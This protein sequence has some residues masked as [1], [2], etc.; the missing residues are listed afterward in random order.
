MRDLLRLARELFAGSRLKLCATLAL[1]A[2]LTSITGVGL[3][4]ILPLLGL[5]GLAP[6]S[7]DNPVWHRLGELLGRFGISLTLVTGL[8]LFAAVVC[9][10]ALLAWRRETWQVEVEQDFQTTLR[11][12]LYESLS[13]TELQYLQRL[14]TSEFVQAT[15]GEI[16]RVQDAV[17]VLFQLV[18]TVLRLLVYFAVALYL[19]PQMTL[20]VFASG[21]LVV[22]AMR[23]M[24]K[25][26]HLLSRQQV[27]VRGSMINNL[28]EHIQGL[29]TARSLGLTQRFIDDYRARSGQAARVAVELTR[30]SSRSALVFEVVAAVLLA[31]LVYVG[32]ARLEVEPARFIV[33]VLVFIRTFPT[34][35]MFQ[36]QLQRLV[37]LVPSFLHYAE[38]LDDLE[39][40]EEK[41]TAG[42]EGPAL[43]LQQ[44]LELRDVSFS[45]HAAAAP[46]LRQV[47]LRIE[48]GA[49]TAIAGQSGAGKSTLVDLVTGLL[50]PG[51]GEILLDGQPLSDEGRFRWRRETALVPQESFLF[52]DS[53][54][55][56][57][58]CVEPGASEEDLWHVLES[59]NCRAFV[60]TRAGGLDSP[61]GERG[62]L[63][64]GGERQRICIA[65]A[66]LRRPQLLVLDEPTNNL[67]AASVAALLDVLER[68]KG[69]AT[70]LVVSHDPR[71]LQ[72]AERVFW[73]ADGALVSG[74][75]RLADQ[76]STRA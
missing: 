39:R 71:V 67:D 31:G 33:L 40:H 55:G 12:R 53:I 56:N 18:S 57:L 72:R 34:I 9:L 27:R 29:R 64:S 61:V 37:E 30:L 74:A 24:V 21:A 69:Q 42:A 50:S 46:A 6:G 35:G 14:K 68:L 3:L 20:L 13:R 60:A 43:T 47:S 65:R 26:T 15:Q 58:L 7:A 76:V 63:L 51:K 23:P 16:R 36:N 19:S 52:N 1:D 32:V 41:G 45:Y 59:V 4:L 48:K 11:H 73:L 62:A 10:R 17:N 38:L 49:M 8:V 2:M 22:L 25:R 66:M 28:V 75:A 70:L 5:L 54:R 44:A